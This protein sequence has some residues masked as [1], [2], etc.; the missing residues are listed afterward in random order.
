MSLLS[1]QELRKHF[2]RAQMIQFGEVRYT[3]TFDTRTG[4][5][6]ALEILVIQILGKI[7]Y[8]N[9]MRDKLENR[10]SNRIRFHIRNIDMEWRPDKAKRQQYRHE[11]ADL[12]KTE[13]RYGRLPSKS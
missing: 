6:K 4:S 9:A 10:E 3:P 13:E 8:G 12:R 2:E 5:Y 11:L 7:A 1:P